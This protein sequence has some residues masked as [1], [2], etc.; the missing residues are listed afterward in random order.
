M[1]PSK[2]NFTIK[3]ILAHFLKARLEM[4]CSGEGYC[5]TNSGCT[6]FRFDVSHIPNI[7]FSALFCKY[8][9]YLQICCRSGFPC[10]EVRRS[11]CLYSLLSK[12]DTFLG[13]DSRMNSWIPSVSG[14]R[15][16]YGTKSLAQVSHRF[17]E[18]D[19]SSVTLWELLVLLKSSIN[20]Y[21]GTI[22]SS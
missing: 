3:I 22:K 13:E 8:K 19:C 18:G 2:C 9:I 20:L 1:Y 11:W 4:Q 12:E 15:R 6:A 21:L 16:P 17:E 5:T 7:H 10:E 14:E